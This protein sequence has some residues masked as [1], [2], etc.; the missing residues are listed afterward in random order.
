MNEIFKKN[1]KLPKKSLEDL[2][3]DGSVITGADVIKSQKEL[4]KRKLEFE[5]S[6]EFEQRN[7]RIKK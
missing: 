2:V 6:I 5:H 4:E 1:I 3:K 7:R